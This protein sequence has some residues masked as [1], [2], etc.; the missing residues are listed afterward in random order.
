VEGPHFGPRRLKLMV[1]LGHVSFVPFKRVG[2]KKKKKKDGQGG[3]FVSKRR[4]QCLRTSSL[5]ACVRGWVRACGRYTH[6]KKKM[7]EEFKVNDVDGRGDICFVAVGVAAATK[8][9][10]R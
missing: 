6:V 1:D 2:K 8:A 5:H 4:H 10:T 3:G 7:I 9:L